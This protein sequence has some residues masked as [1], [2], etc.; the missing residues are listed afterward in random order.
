MAISEYFSLL[1]LNPSFDIDLQELEKAYFAQQRLFHPDRFVGKPHAERLVA[2][3]KSADINK[4][5]ETLK[6]PLKRAQYLLHL[7]GIAVGTDHDT[8]KP[9]QAL[10]MEVIEL[11]EEAV[12]KDII[13]QM[14]VQSQA[15]IAQHCAD[16]KWMDM[17]HET[18]R[19]GYMVKI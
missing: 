3:G 5:Y 11:R 19:L 13:T 12:T 4:A 7:Q 10:L 2:L 1:S 8:V 18:L 15:A 6:N 17:A 16:E 9:T 14:V